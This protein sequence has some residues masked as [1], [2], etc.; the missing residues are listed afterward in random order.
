MY[1]TNNIN[2][3]SI[4]LICTFIGIPDIIVDAYMLNII[5]LLFVLLK[6]RKKHLNLLFYIQ[7]SIKT[8][9]KQILFLDHTSQRKKMK[10]W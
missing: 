6:R 7:I 8:P 9:L 1:N 2:Y 5:A 3:Y 10:K 4:Q